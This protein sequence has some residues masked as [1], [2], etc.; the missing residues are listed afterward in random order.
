MIKAYFENFHPLTPLLDEITFKDH[1]QS[2]QR[3]DDRWKALLCM[4]F[5]LGSIAA[6]RANNML[7]EEYFNR[8]KRYLNLDALG[9]PHLETVQTLSLMGGHYLHY[10][11]QPHLAYCLVGAALRMAATLGIHREFSGSNDGKQNSLAELRRR[12]WWSLLCMDTWGCE[13]LGRPSLGRWGPG[14]TAK[15]PQHSNGRVSNSHSCLLGV[16]TGVIK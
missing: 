7:H 2:G 12:V 4:V 14:I 10:I 11:S 16:H 9:Q 6:N 5:A 13:T 8:A 15:L 1:Y 3:V